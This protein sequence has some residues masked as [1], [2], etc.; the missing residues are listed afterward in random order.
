M[1]FLICHYFSFD[2]LYG[3][4]S[5]TYLRQA[6]DFLSIKP[7]SEFWPPMYAVTGWMLSLVFHNAILSLQLTSII[8]LTISAFLLIQIIQSFHKDSNLAIVFVAISYLLSPFAV[9]SGIVI[10][11]DA[12]ATMFCLL[13]TYFIFVSTNT[14]K[15]FFALLFASFAL[16]SRYATAVVLFP[17]IA[18]ELFNGIKQKQWLFIFC[19]CSI[20]LILM[21]LNFAYWASTKGSTQHEWLQ[22]WQLKNIFL[23]SF[24]TADGSSTNTLPNIIYAFKNIFYPGFLLPFLALLFF[25]KKEDFE[26]KTSQLILSSVL[27]YAFFLAGIPFQNER[28]LLLT[29]PFV[30]VLLFPAFLR[31]TE[32]KPFMKYSPLFFTILALPLIVRAAYPMY[33]LNQLE[34]DIGE[35]LANYQGKTLYA[36]DIDVA[37]QGRGYHFDYRNLWEKKY[38]HFDKNSLVIFNEEKFFKQWENKNPMLNFTSLKNNYTLTVEKNLPEGWTLF[39]IQ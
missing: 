12:I 8:S 21:Y 17:L 36:F 20:A 23:R 15:I 27:L 32:L 22:S 9:R 34:K 7:Q 30:I 1:L 5:Y 26:K 31:M 39:S 10:M 18:F 3:Q 37:L 4:D 28:F 25:L 33:Q 14:Y 24:T 19:G 35:Q 2:G 38:D 6:K 16:L 11:S 13:T 29:F